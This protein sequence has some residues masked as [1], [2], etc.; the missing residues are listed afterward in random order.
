MR[1]GLFPQPLDVLPLPNGSGLKLTTARYYTPSG[2]AIQADGIHPDV[3]VELPRAADAPKITRER[4]LP[5]S[6]P[7]EANAGDAGARTAGGPARVVSVD[8][9]A[10]LDDAISF[11]LARDVPSDPTTGKDVVLRVG[12]ELVRKKIA[13][14]APR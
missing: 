9:G 4:D 13:E 5:G 14:R 8:A 12:Y 10:P 7:P 3:V 1:L 6:L 2:H 11:A